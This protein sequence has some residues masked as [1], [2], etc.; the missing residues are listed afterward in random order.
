LLDDELVI[1]LMIS[2]TAKKNQP[3]LCGQAKQMFQ[4]YF[5]DEVSYE[6]WEHSD[7]TRVSDRYSFRVTEFDTAKIIAKVE[8]LKQRLS[9]V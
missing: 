4:D 7:G 2:P 6:L 1:D 3:V 8:E 9:S 5:G